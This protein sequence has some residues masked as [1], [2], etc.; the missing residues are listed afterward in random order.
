MHP[1]D[2]QRDLKSFGF[3]FTYWQLRNLGTSKFQSLWLIWV[4]RNIA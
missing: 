4:A 3:W 2:V 1:F